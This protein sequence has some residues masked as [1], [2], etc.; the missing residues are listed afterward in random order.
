VVSSRY[1]SYSSLVSI[2]LIIYDQKWVSM[3]R[4]LSSGVAP[5]LD[6]NGA[7]EIS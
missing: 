7:K 3:L 5:L 4:N 2:V 1:A 6:S